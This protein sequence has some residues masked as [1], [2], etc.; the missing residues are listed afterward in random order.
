MILHI[1]GFHC[2]NKCSQCT[3]SVSI[4]S[5][6]NHWSGHVGLLIWPLWSHDFNHLDLVSGGK[7]AEVKVQGMSNHAQ[8]LS[9]ISWHNKHISCIQRILTFLSHT[10]VTVTNHTHV[11]ITFFTWTISD[12]T[13]WS[14]D[15]Q[16]TICTMTCINDYIFEW[17]CC[18]TNSN[19]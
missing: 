7:C 1:L 8:L 9:T 19:F 2:Y 10:S 6:P 12:I 13:S 11:H 17:C 3:S 14:H 18:K 16:E 5:F 15:S 4:H